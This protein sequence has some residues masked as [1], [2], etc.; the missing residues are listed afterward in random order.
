MGDRPFPVIQDEKKLAGKALFVV[1]HVWL[2]PVVICIIADLDEECDF[3]HLLVTI[4]SINEVLLADTVSPEDA[5]KLQDLVVQYFSL[6]KACSDRLPSVFGK[7]HFIEH[8]AAQI[9][10]YGRCISA[11]VACYESRHRDFVNGCESS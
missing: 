9:L 8:Y 11:W 3:V 5:L 2:M 7:H 6:R 1:L 4:H 10:K